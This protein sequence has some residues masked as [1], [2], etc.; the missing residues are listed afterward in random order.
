MTPQNPTE[1]PQGDMAPTSGHG[2]PLPTTA[3]KPPAEGVEGDYDSGWVNENQPNT[4]PSTE[5]PIPR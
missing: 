4:K 5:A 1:L 2:E 3:D